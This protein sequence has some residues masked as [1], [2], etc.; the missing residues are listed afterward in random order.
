[1]VQGMQFK[2]RLI[3]DGQVLGPSDYAKVHICCPAVD[4]IVNHIYELNRMDDQLDLAEVDFDEEPVM[5]M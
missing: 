2:V 1:M 4:K 5:R 3:L